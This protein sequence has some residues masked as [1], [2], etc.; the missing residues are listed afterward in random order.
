MDV[1]PT[2]YAL[3]SGSH[4]IWLVEMTLSFKENRKK[5]PKCVSNTNTYILESEK[6]KN[7]C[8]VDLYRC[9]EV[10]CWSLSRR[11]SLVLCSSGRRHQIPLWTHPLETQLL[12]GAALQALFTS[13]NQCV[14][15]KA[16]LQDS[17]G[18]TDESQSRN[19][20][21]ASLFLITMQKSEKKKNQ[22]LFESP[23]NLQE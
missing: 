17:R 12:P 3:L 18:Y 21:A 2:R 16:S 7:S 11:L 8:S 10:I 5:Q 23:V 22:F 14:K 1:L 4:S 20:P 19:C 9:L 13:N 15:V 6:K